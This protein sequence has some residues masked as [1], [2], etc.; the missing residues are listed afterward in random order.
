MGSEITLGP[1]HNFRK[2][3]YTHGLRNGGAEQRLR[4]RGQ[5]TKISPALISARARLRETL[6]TLLGAS[7]SYDE[8]GVRVIASESAVSI[9]AFYRMAPS[10]RDLDKVRLEPTC[11]GC[12]VNLGRPRAAKWARASACRLVSM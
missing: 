12:S 10:R 2:F 11:I 7:S 6:M 5:E 1:P 8:V 9:S 4:V 3:I